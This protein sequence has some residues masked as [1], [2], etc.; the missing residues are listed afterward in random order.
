MSRESKHRTELG[1]TGLRV[2]R[3][4]LGTGGHFCLGQRDGVPEKEIHKLIHEALEIGYNL[5]DTSPGYM[6][7]ELILRRALVGVSRDRYF[8][9]DKVVVSDEE[10]GVP[11]QEEIRR[12]VESSLKRLGVDTVDILLVAGSCLTRHYEKMRNEHFP[13]LRRMQKEG[14]IRFIGSSEKSSVDGTH[15]W[16]SKGLKDDLFDVVMAGYNIF[17]QVADR[18]IYP[19]CQK[20]NVGVLNIY[21]VRNAFRDDQRL[22]ETIDDL[23][24]RNLL[25]GNFTTE[26]FL[27]LIPEGETPASTAYKFA[28]AHDAVSTIM[29]TSSSIEHL[30]Q[31][32][33]SIESN[34]LPQEV[35]SEFRELFSNIGEPVGM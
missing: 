34:P 25:D 26:E 3:L 16:L 4:G 27:A 28:A 12:S 31:N 22:T 24:A 33:T 21:T 35:I 13:I 20:N 19:L 6:D 10:Q 17:N 15:E 29:V 9:S 1:R 32:V 2:S 8:L 23:K 5:F 14:K 30:R 7:S 18:N 11:S